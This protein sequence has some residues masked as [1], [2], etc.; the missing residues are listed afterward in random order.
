MSK[1]QQTAFTPEDAGY[2]ALAIQLAKKG[3]FTTTPN[4]NVG[5]VIVNHQQ[6]VGEGWHQYAGGPHAEVI[7]LTA[8]GTAAEGATCYV[9]LEPC[10]HFGRTP[11]CVD[12]LIKAKVARVVVAVEDPNP[13]VSGRGLQRLRNAGIEVSTNLLA[14]QAKALNSGYM[15]RMQGGLPLIRIK[16]AASIDGKTALANGQSQ[17]ITSSHARNDVQQYRALSCGVISGADT[18][19]MDN[20][21]LTVR[22]EQLADVTADLSQHTL[23]Q[24]LRVILDTQCRLTPELKLFSHQSPIILVRLQ[25]DDHP[26]PA[27]VEQMVVPEQNGRADLQAVVKGLAE[28]GCNQLWLEAG[29]RLAGAFIEAGL[30]DE[31]II[32][33]APK[34]IGNTGRSLAVLPE[35]QSMTEVNALQIVDLVTIGPDIRITLCDATPDD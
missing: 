17:W 11:P 32:Y 18:V 26:W 27:H 35:R 7:A 15:R 8:A 13:Q 24:P 14:E 28:R 20:A 9:T 16:L 4:P 5:C 1:E 12:A 6:I 25:V 19:I 21:S 3:R 22:Y 23:R 34:L 30:M 10:S 33:Q 2:M 29:A 31:L